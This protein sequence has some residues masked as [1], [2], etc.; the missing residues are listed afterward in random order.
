MENSYDLITTARTM[1][2][3]YVAVC[4]KCGLIFL[5]CGKAPKKQ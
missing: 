3:K 4:E 2:L 1:A 5:D